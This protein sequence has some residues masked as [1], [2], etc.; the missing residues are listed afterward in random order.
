[1]K[2]R[3]NKPRQT[4]ARALV[5]IIDK[6]QTLDRA[7]E[8][9][10]P[11]A[12]KA[13]IQEMLYGV[14]RWYHRLHALTEALLKQGLKK[15][16]RDVYMLLLVG[17]YELL[18]MDNE[19]YAVVNETVS[20][21]NTLG[22]SWAKGLLNACLRR[23][24]REH[25]ALQKNLDQNDA[26]HY[27]HPDWFIDLVRNQ[28][29]HHWQRVL[30]ANNERPPMHLRVNTRTTTRADYLALLAENGMGAHALD[31]STTAIALA[32]PMPVDKLPAFDRGGVSVQDGAAQLAA[33]LLDV[34][35]GD[36]VLDACA[37]PGGKAGHLLERHPEMGQ[38]V[39][40][41]RSP[42]RSEHIVENFRRLGVDAVIKIADAACPQDWWD[43]RL[44]QRILLDAPCSATGVIRRHPDIKL[45]RTLQHIAEATR[46]QRKILRALWPL[47]EP[48]GKLLYV[49]CSI[50][51]A[52]NQEQ[53][54]AFL[55]E[56]TDATDLALDLD[57]AQQRCPGVQILP[58]TKGLD[59]FYY[60]CLQKN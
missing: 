60:A 24:Q 3:H 27:S 37:A 34:R 53:I 10:D 35:P 19:Q 5:R 42:G 2:S 23:A 12:N 41:E 31:S 18:Y 59:G 38:L 22:K 17:L 54:A 40:V 4:A 45:H 32:T 13:L 20:A 39:L 8:A 57:W 14:L 36:R 25:E 16:D 7:L 26:S 52:E 21:A 11:S 55:G 44:F 49:T 58:G 9:I 43:G 46:L 29:P 33:E 50:L 1:M 51:S 47:L 30:Q 48:G 28:Y 6:G 56:R 15:R